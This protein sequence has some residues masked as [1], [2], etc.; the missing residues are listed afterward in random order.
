MG[1]VEVFDQEMVCVEEKSRSEDYPD[2]GTDLSL[3]LLLHNCTEG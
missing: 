1:R 2:E 3:G